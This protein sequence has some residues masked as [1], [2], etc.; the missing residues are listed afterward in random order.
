MCRP[1]LWPLFAAVA[2]AA[3]ASAA[4][5]QAA[6]GGALDGRI[7]ISWVGDPP[8]GDQLER[9]QGTAEIRLQPGRAARGRAVRAL[10]KAGQRVHP[11]W[12]QG[13]SFSRVR[14]VEELSCSEG[15]T[16]HIQRRESGRI[17][18][19]LVPFEPVASPRLNM[20]TGKG[21]MAA[22]PFWREKP[23]HS[24]EPFYLPVESRVEVAANEV[25]CRI[26]REGD[27]AGGIYEQSIFSPAGDE[28]I[29]WAFALWI[30]EHSM[31]LRRV[32]GIWRAR[33]TGRY[34]DSWG[35]RVP[36]T[37][38]Y[39]LNL[40]LRGTPRSYGAICHFPEARI[41][42][43]RSVKAALRLARRAGYPHA[44]YAGTHAYYDAPPGRLIVED[45]GVYGDR[46]CGTRGG[47]R[48]YRSA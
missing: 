35:V 23:Y 11:A 25:P 6:V 3:A 24:A 15:G 39:K 14:S 44:R 7:G 19:P 30:N 48:I 16:E 32:K 2:I 18:Q 47:P 31:R 13:A 8:P 36:V 28:V 12:I 4:P 20:L 27:G 5:S 21:E 29:P 22:K 9:W 38:K 34:R 33:Y 45:G 41:E 43:M 17:V 26:P 10:K 1:P 42:R 37:L 46:P 40:R